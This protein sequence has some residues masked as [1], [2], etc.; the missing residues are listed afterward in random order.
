MNLAQNIIDNINKSV[1]NEKASIDWNNYLTP[2]EVERFLNKDDKVESAENIIY[3]NEFKDRFQE[4]KKSGWTRRELTQD[5]AN[6][7][8]KGHLTEGVHLYGFVKDEDG[9]AKII[10]DYDYPDKKSFERDLKGNGYTVR[11][12]NDNRDMYII[13]HSDFLSIANVKSEINRLKKDL[14]FNK[15]HGYDTL[16]AEV[17]LKIDKLENLIKEANNISLTE[18]EESLWKSQMEQKDKHQLEVYL[19][20]LYRQL[21]DYNSDEI[22]SNDYYKLLS[23]I[24]YIESKI[25]HK[26]KL[27]RELH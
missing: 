12:V 20:K 16:V 23:K 10:E 7:Y 9:N 2:K 27:G 5:L 21:R 17:Q 15:E 22:K 24:E 1:L 6:F 19:D 11:R 13:D 14:Q 4:F 18:S 3:D 8:Y 26:P 25:G